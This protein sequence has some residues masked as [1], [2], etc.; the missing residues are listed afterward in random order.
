MYERAAIKCKD[1]NVDTFLVNHCV[2][3]FV[4]RN[5]RFYILHSWHFNII[6]KNSY[7]GNIYTFARLS[8]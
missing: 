7:I 2:F 3:F 1:Y 6:H 4:F 8:P 5:C